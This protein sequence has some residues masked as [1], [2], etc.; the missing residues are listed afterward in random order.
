MLH[1]GSKN[2]LKR[3]N[4]GGFVTCRESNTCKV[5]FEKGV[6]KVPKGR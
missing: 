3:A 6:S 4:L 1:F 2:G 5:A